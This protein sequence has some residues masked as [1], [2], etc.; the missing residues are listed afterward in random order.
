MRIPGIPFYSAHSSNFTA[1]RGKPIRKLTIH[2][3]AALNDTLRYL[4]GDATRNGSSTFFCRDTG[5]EQYVDT[6]DTPWTNS[7]FASNQ[8]SITIEVNGDWRNGYY[9]QATLN[10]LE[11][12][13]TKI[14]GF[15]PNLIIEYHMD[16]STKVTLC[17]ADLKHKGWAAQVFSNAKKRLAPISTPA[18]PVPPQSKITY[19]KLTPKR[20]QLIRPT[21]LWDF[22]FTDY[23]KAQA[24]GEV[25]PAGWTVDVVAQA[26]NQLGSKY[27]MTA[28]SYDG[29][30]IRYTRGFNV[31]DTKDYVE[32]IAPPKP[33]PTPVEPKPTTPPIAP[34][35]DTDPGTVGNSDIE[36]RLSAIEAFIDSFKKLFIGGN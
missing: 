10:Q 11:L 15:Y 35:I 17:P 30:K 22:N 7:N 14:L 23:S 5:S 13:C 21:R 33:P 32:V 6:D 24:I 8:E 20:V 1:G 27:L 18:T 12:L 31:V 16:V 25:Y 19:A 9:N 2:H 3:T 36:K 28:Y 34:P 29:G 4:W 26:T